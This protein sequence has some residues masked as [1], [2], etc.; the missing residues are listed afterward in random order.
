MASL[1]TD[2]PVQARAE[3]VGADRELLAP[4]AASTTRR[5]DGRHRRPRRW[6]GWLPRMTRGR[7][8][9]MLAVS[10]VVL[11]GGTLAVNAAATPGGPVAAQPA[12]T[13]PL[14]LPPVDT[15]TPDS[16][17]PVCHLPAPTTTPPLTGVPLP[18]PTG[19]STPVTCFP[20]SLQY[21][22]LH[23]T[24]AP[25]ATAPPPCTG[26]GCIPQPT[27]SAPAPSN[28]GTGQSGDSGNGDADCGITN[29]GGCIT[30]AINGFFRG[31]VTAALNPLLDLLS[32]TLLT[33]P[34]PDSLPRIGELWNNSW[35]ILLAS[36]ALLILIAGI[37]V[38][39]YETVQTR[40]SI[41]EIAPRIVVGF[42]AGA[43]SLWVA[44]KAIEIANG[45]AQ[46]VMGGGLDASSA[47]D[48]LKNL[49][50][51]SLNG[52]IFI[53]FI[54]IFLAGML[55]VL[56]VTYIVRV[57]LTIILIAGAPIA[58]MCHALPQT[59]GIAR[60]WWK[61]FGGCLAIQ[62]GQSLTLITAMKVFLA[63]GGFTLFGPTLSGLVNL[64]VALALMY[65]LFK[66]PF[67]FLGSLRGGG[68]RSLLG[69]IVRGFIA[70]KTFGLLCG[71]G[72]GGGRRPRPSGGGGGGNGGGGRGPAD[73][74]ARTRS[75]GD[76][77]YLL[78]LA[79]V[80]R[81]R[82]A[83]TPKPAPSAGKPR[84][85]RGR[86]LALPLGDDWPENKPVLGRDGQYR[87]P[88]DVQRVT[89]TPPPPGQGGRPRGRPRGG[90][91]LELPFD[92]YKGNRAT[93]SGQ[94]P[95]PLG[96]TRTPRPASSPPVTP[97]PSRPR[98]TQLELPF[99]PYK[100]NRATRSGQ[101][102]LPF[103]GIKR[104]PATPASP[105][106]SA[107]PSSAPPSAAPSRP[108][109]RPGSQLRLPLDLP[110]PPRPTP[111]PPVSGGGQP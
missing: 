19:P 14:P 39:G 102:P 78:P 64:L 51:S 98:G 86:Q 13:P 104:V 23:P 65:I 85:G 44:T 26:E 80:R 15:C 109:P 62:V 28:P 105:P 111:P 100:G 97:P 6:T 17:L 40:H 27:T 58:L 24:T 91:Q 12:P 101:Y 29:I 103:D 53:I 32:K 46:A 34:T 66:I 84:A 37:L 90:G 8:L 22:C 89:P 60:W 54:G 107:P 30:N 1:H 77:Q 57:A 82:P 75:T 4:P 10:L 11:L 7:A 33:T 69:S 49:V 74:Y 38:M 76:G 61:A 72:G 20:G 79:G 71:R 50:L 18:L 93:R 59:E 95:L 56:L 106:S 5:A 16:P 31:I 3:A 67:W 25:T 9:A 88:L 87:L 2:A 36:Y 35:Q 63:P 92:P 55:I 99:D 21:E 43:L 94:Y 48:T 83:A 96:V 41:K 68:G 108:A 52:G 110:K 42:L 70:Y 81:S 45:L 73:P 47:G